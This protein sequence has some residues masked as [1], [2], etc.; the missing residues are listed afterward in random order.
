MSE[1][2]N[3]AAGSQEETDAYVAS[4][5]ALLGDRDP[6]EVQQE[7]PE[8]VAQAIAGLDEAAVRRPEKPGKWSIAQVVQHLADSELV[9]GYRVRSV[10]A[11][12]GTALQGYDQDLWA[13]ELGYETVS[14]QDSLAQLRA[15]RA[16]NLRLLRRLSPAQL[17]RT[18]LHSERGAESV[19]RMLRLTAA[20]DLLHRRQIERIKQAV[21]GAPGS[22]GKRW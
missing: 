4:L 21:A 8:A 16:A 14:L 10:A 15:L 13:R 3:A 17:E 9:T 12:A 2:S 18:G 1:F 5:L 19:G 7:L 11:Q 22:E 20:H 6:L